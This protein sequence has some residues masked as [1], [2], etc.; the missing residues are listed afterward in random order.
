MAETAAAATCPSGAVDRLEVEVTGV[1]SAR[2]QVAVTVYPD[3]RRRFLAP[4]GRL[5]RVRVPVTTPTTTACLRLPGP[6]SYAV[7]VYH[8]Q[9]SDRDF[10]RNALGLPTEG[11]GFSNDAPTPVGLPDL[12]AVRFRAEAGVHRIRVRMRYR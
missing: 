4:G 3:S 1:R 11:F 10:N 8:D 12:A 9:N 7:A 5:D 6:G 2:G